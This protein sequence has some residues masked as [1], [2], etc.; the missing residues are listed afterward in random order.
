MT[1]KTTD[2]ITST[3]LE[4]KKQAEENKKKLISIFETVILCGHQQ[5]ALRGK[6][7]TGK[8]ADGSMFTSSTIQNE[9]IYLCFNLI[10]ENVVNRI[11]NAGFFTIF[12]DKTQ[13]ISRYKQL[14]LGIRYVDDPSADSVFIGEDFLEFAH[15]KDVTT[16]A[17]ATTI[18]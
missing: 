11:K 18:M 17:L 8:I 10:Q 15:V 2:I 7:E 14:T 16:S 1:R 12:A 3:S 4:N 9:I 13:D 6:N 5:I